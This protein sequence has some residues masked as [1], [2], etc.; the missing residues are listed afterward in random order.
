[1]FMA[2]SSYGHWRELRDN[3]V[4]YGDAPHL[5][6][7]NDPW[8]GTIPIP[9]K[10][11]EDMQQE[12]FWTTH[13]IKFGGNGLRPY[14]KIM[15]LLEEGDAKDP[16][17]Y[18]SEIQVR[19]W[20]EYEVWKDERTDPEEF[21]RSWNYRGYAAIQVAQGLR[22]RD[23]IEA[24]L[25]ELEQRKKSQ[26]T[27]LTAEKKKEV[28]AFM[29]KYQKEMEK[30]DRKR[31]KDFDKTEE[32]IVAARERRAER[33]KRGVR[34]AASSPNQQEPG[35]SESGDVARENRER[36]ND[37]LKEACHKRPRTTDNFSESPVE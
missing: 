27:S 6:H 31:I 34:R 21:A 11:I 28:D 22:T 1:M 35:T 25:V 20:P 10:F 8:G 32:G 5:V 3:P 26:E 29:K 2:V 4:K 33:I 15:G 18:R 13:I 30:F 23:R 19:D 14:P 16:K 9:L 37:H 17:A 36:W 7:E 12:E 24:R